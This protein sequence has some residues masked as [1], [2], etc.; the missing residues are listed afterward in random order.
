MENTGPRL[1]ELL[2]TG[3][4]NGVKTGLNKAFTISRVMRDRLM[5]QDPSSSELIKPLIV[6]DD[7]RRYEVHFRDSYLIYVRWDTDIKRYP[8]I[9]TWLNNFRSDLEERDSTKNGGPCPWY[10]L[11]RPRP[12]SQRHNENPK[13]VYGQIM[14][15]PRFYLDANFYFTNQKCFFLATGDWFLLAVLNSD[16]AWSYLKSISVAF[17]DPDSGGR[18]EPRV[19]N[20]ESIPIPAASEAERNAVAALARDAQRSHGERRAR[21]ERFLHDC[22]LDPATST[23]RNPLEQ[24]WRIDVAEFTRRVLGLSATLFI[25]A[26]DETAAQTA[27][28]ARYEAEID[29]R[30]AALYGL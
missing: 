30:V 29:A 6:G 20:I 1:G 23:S 19:E 3:A 15:T 14:M 24:P 22:G 10:A 9:L 8:A 26:R 11:S 5:E 28:I 16:A 4:I 7:I 21:V 17:G 25:A 18:L 13:I 12:E 2:K 27:D